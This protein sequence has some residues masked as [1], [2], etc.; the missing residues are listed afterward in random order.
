[1]S[2]GDPFARAE[3]SAANLRKLTGTPHFDSAVVLG[4]YSFSSAA[5]RCFSSS[6]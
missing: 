4:S 6:R 3:A 2:H 1:M 5:N